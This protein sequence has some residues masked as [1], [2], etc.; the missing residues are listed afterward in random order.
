[1]AN[2]LRGEVSFQD[3]DQTFTFRMGVNQLLDFQ[4][5]MGLAGQDEKL[6]EALDNLRS[7]SVMRKIIYC[8]LIKSHPEITEEDAGEIISNLGLPKIAEI[9]MEA[10]RWALPDKK[11]AGPADDKGKPRPS[12]GPKS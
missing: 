2:H 3:G 9:V 10:L 5:R 7:L 12:R 4:E 1:M 8:G 6:W 11:E